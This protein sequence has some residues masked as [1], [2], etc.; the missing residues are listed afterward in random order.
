M[1]E[2]Y[3]TLPFKSSHDIHADL[4]DAYIEVLLDLKKQIESNTFPEN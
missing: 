1:C 2:K 4:P 3:L